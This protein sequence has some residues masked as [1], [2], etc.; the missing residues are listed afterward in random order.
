MTTTLA[1]GLT[2]ALR[3]TAP[4][5]VMTPQPMM[6]ARSNGMSRD[7]TIAPDCGTTVYS[8]CVDVTKKWCTGS[9]SRCMRDVPSSSSPRG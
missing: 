1:P 4:T 9:P 8:A 2:F 5:P 6:Q 3:T 7:T